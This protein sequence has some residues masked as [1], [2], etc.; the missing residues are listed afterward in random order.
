[1]HART[2]IRNEIARLLEEGI[3]DVAGRVF[4]S[5]VSAIDPADMPCLA[6][7]VRGEE[8]SAGTVLG[9]GKRRLRRV[10]E[11]VVSAM[12]AGGEDPIGATEDLLGQVEAVLADN[13]TIGGLVQQMTPTALEVDK[14]DEGEV[15]IAGGA[16]SYAAT[17]HTREGTPGAPD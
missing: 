16:V 14:D 1:M 2:A 5:P 6:V 13:P 9:G 10:A 8:V 7:F 17:Y 4:R 15:P 11:V 3:P 12:V